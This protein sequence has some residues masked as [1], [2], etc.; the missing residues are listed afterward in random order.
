MEK[1]HSLKKWKS[2]KKN[3]FS[4]PK[5]ISH[6]SYEAS[7]KGRADLANF[8]LLHI[9]ESHKNHFNNGFY[10]LSIFS[11]LAEISVPGL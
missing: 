7:K 11:L 6:I 9:F 2:V 3:I 5:P 1:K 10:T 8:K 4:I